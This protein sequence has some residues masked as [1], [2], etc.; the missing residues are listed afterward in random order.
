MQECGAAGPCFENRHGLACCLRQLSMR[1]SSAFPL[2]FWVKGWV[3]HASHDSSG[4][5]H[6]SV[7]VWTGGGRRNGKRNLV[8]ALGKKFLG[9][10]S[11][12]SLLLASC[13]P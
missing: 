12:P 7:G 11:V 4:W 6:G 5:M 8:A 3:C 13:A 1:S 10:S 9:R 2:G